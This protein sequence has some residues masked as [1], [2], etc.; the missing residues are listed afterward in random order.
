MHIRRYRRRYIFI[1]V[2]VDDIILVGKDERRIKNIKCALSQKFNIK[3][4]GKLHHFLGMKIVQDENSEDI[5]IGQPA[6]ISKILHKF[7]MQDCKPVSTPVDP[8]AKLTKSSNTEDSHDRQRSQS[9]IGA[10]LYLSVSTRPDITYSVGTLAKLS[11]NPTK[12]HWTALKRVMQYLKG[13]ANYGIVYSRRLTMNYLMHEYLYKQL[14]VHL[15]KIN[16]TT[17][18]F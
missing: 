4:M 8:G 6:Y 15:I 2:Y 16:T 11:S 7:G 18:C 13:T 12:Q 10:L 17:M 5:W 14:Q 9:A 3:D 1:G